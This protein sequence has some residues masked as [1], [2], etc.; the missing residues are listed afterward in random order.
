MSSNPIRLQLLLSRYI[1]NSISSGELE[2]FWQLMSELSDDDLVQLDLKNLW[3]READGNP[4][5]EVDWV[6]ANQILRQKIFEQ[7]FSYEQRLRIVKRRQYIYGSAAAVL[8][9]LAGALIWRLSLNRQ[10]PAYPAD[11]AIVV[12][13]GRHQTISLPDGTMVTLNEGSKLDYPAAFNQ[14]SR[15]VYLT[16]EAFFDV[17]HDAKKPFLVHAGRFT[18]RVLGTAFNIRAY[19]GDPNM[20]VTVT[21]GRVQ[22]Q[23]D[24]NKETLGILS[25]GDQLI[26]DRVSSESSIE[27]VDVQKVVEWKL[28]DLVFDNATVDEGIIALGNRYGKTFLF[29]N[30]ALRNCRFTANFINDN[31]EESLDVICTLI[32]AQWTRREGTDVI[33]I[34]GK[35]CVA[36]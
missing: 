34:S 27:K 7:E 29:D 12:K 14:S 30:E 16:G 25:A 13:S 15:D 19:P 36:E 5:A 1:D 3:N 6:R 10:T 23:S 26:I 17:K 33:I 18:T 31:L 28:T 11:K 2:E 4:A 9:I 35:G 24:G 21:R 22:I 20:A 32:N 8:M